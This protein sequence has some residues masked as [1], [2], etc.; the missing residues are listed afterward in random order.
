MSPHNK[1]KQNKSDMP[2][3]SVIPWSDFTTETNNYDAILSAPIQAAGV[4]PTQY[5]RFTIDDFINYLNSLKGAGAS[6]VDVHMSVTNAS[7]SN[8]L[9]V[10]FTAAG[11]TEPKPL[12]TVAYDMGETTP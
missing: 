1:N 8:K 3:G 4:S 5:V 12:A 9:S 2:I 10:I 11:A 6:E 7:G